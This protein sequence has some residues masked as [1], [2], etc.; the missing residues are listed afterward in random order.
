M[1]TVLMDA[2]IGEVAMCQCK[3][4]PSADHNTCLDG[5][6][7]KQKEQFVV[8]PGTDG[9]LALSITRDGISQKISADDLFAG[10]LFGSSFKACSKAASG[11]S[12][13]T[14]AGGSAGFSGLYDGG[15]SIINSLLPFNASR[16]NATQ[17]RRILQSDTPNLLGIQ[18]PIICLKV[19]QGT[20][21]Q[22][23]PST[24]DLSK[25]HYPVYSRNSLFNSNTN[26]DY[27]AFIDLK[28]RISN[29]QLIKAFFYSFTDPGMYSFEDSIDSSKQMFIGVVAASMECPSAF[30]TNAIQPM[31][32]SIL[33]QFPDVRT[34]SASLT[35]MPDYGLIIGLT[36]G[37]VALLVL[38]SLTVFLLKKR[39]FGRHSRSGLYRQSKFN[40]L[41]DIESHVATEKR[42]EV[43]LV[44]SGV[45]SIDLEGFNVNTLWSVMQK[46]T[47]VLNTELSHQKEEVRDFYDKVLR[48]IG[49]IP[50][51]LSQ[52]GP[53]QEVS[54]TSTNARAIVKSPAFVAS[55][56][57]M[58]GLSS[59]IQ[60]DRSPHLSSSLSPAVSSS[61]PVEQLPVLP[62]PE[63]LLSQKLAE[64]K[65]L[66]DADDAVVLR[67]VQ[68]FI[69]DYKLKCLGELPAAHVS[70]REAFGAAIEKKRD[71]IMEVV[72]EQLELSRGR[73]L[74]D[75]NVVDA[76]IA[77][78]EAD[79]LL[80]KQQLQS[81]SRDPN[82]SAIEL[83]Q[84]RI[85]IEN[86]ESLINDLN[87]MAINHQ[88][89]RKDLSQKLREEFVIPM[90]N[91]SVQEDEKKALI[92]RMHEKGERMDKEL[93]AEQQRQL[94]MA[95]KSKSMAK[96]R[97]IERLAKQRAVIDA[98]L[99]DPINA[100]K[101]DLSS[102]PLSLESIDESVRQLDVDLSK[103]EAE[104]LGQLK[105]RLEVQKKEVLLQEAN[106]FERSIACI[107]DSSSDD[108]DALRRK[109]DEASSRISNYLD[110]EQAKQE[111][112]LSTAFAQLK[113]RKKIKIQQ[114]LLLQQQ[115]Q[116]LDAEQ[117]AQLV[118]EVVK[119]KQESEQQRIQV[120]SELVQEAA[121]IEAEKRSA[122]QDEKLTLT[123]LINDESD[124]AQKE[125]LLK[126]I[127]KLDQSLDSE[128]LRQSEDFKRR[129]EQAKAAKA[130][131]LQ[132]L[133]ERQQL[134]LQ[135]VIMEMDV[136]VEAL[137]CASSLH[138]DSDAEEALLLSHHKQLDDLNTDFL[139]RLEVERSAHQQEFERLRAEQLELKEQLLRQQEQERRD[140]EA[141]LLKESQ[142]FELEMKQKQE[143]KKKEMEKRLKQE[144]LESSAMSEDEKAK[145]LKHH[146][147]QIASLDREMAAEKA[148]QQEILKEKIAERRYRVRLQEEKIK[149]D[150][151]KAEQKLREELQSKLHAAEAEQLAKI[152]ASEVDK[153]K[154]IKAAQVMLHER[155]RRELLEMN[156][157]HMADVAQAT[158]S[159]LQH[160][161]ISHGQKLKDA[162]AIFERSIEGLSGQA[163]DK[164]KNDHQMMVQRMDDKF[165]LEQTEVEGR[166]LQQVADKHRQEVAMF[167]RRREAE[168]RQGAV[169]EIIDI[170]PINNATDDIAAQ[171]LEQTRIVNEDKKLAL[172]KLFAE[173]EKFMADQR[174]KAIAEEEAFLARLQEEK[175]KAIAELTAQQQ[176]ELEAQKKQLQDIQSV[177]E[178]ELIIKRHQAKAQNIEEDLKAER[179][180]QER[181]AAERF[182]KMKQRK[183][184]LRKAKV[185][186]DVNKSSEIAQAQVL[187][188]RIVRQ[189]TLNASSESRQREAL[190]KVIEIW[191]SVC[192]QVRQEHVKLKAVTRFKEMLSQ[193]IKRLGSIESRRTHPVPVATNVHNVSVAPGP[194]LSISDP[195][196][197]EQFMD[198]LQ[199]S[200][201]SRELDDIKRL[202]QQ[203]TSSKTAAAHHDAPVV[204]KPGASSAPKKK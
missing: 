103:Q 88:S 64:S 55:N 86:D 89:I 39:G 67:H 8:G 111:K 75:N 87:E 177:E 45:S 2:S 123:K 84:L 146:Q 175:I 29:G 119:H 3:C 70:Q 139:E 38:S 127:S 26:F 28:D 18:S 71:E 125:L 110:M 10:G 176:R 138:D 40:A 22:V 77:R 19:G 144:D 105:Q 44:S 145:V 118:A 51:I 23:I 27:G 133:E 161:E 129:M 150:A 191:Q 74:R 179:S 60:G 80:K 58:V 108:R 52:V 203:L 41:G 97:R 198:L 148:R 124:E 185:I 165:K 173:K 90:L 181:A 201:L 36:A 17:G 200:S 106:R 184:E 109:Y 72:K 135:N 7:V 113:E 199:R 81:K 16:S 5:S 9:S 170:D 31:S 1:D 68:D 149:A 107:P 151:E 137:V 115:Q 116:Q 63:E 164:A 6:S 158:S 57:E 156:A 204:H 48:E 98:A 96:Q 11:C 202:L 102:S 65:I 35:L 95:E 142:Q 174:V 93:Y 197:Q 13:Q 47:T 50:V 136:K 186:Q 100:S 37:L 59:N 122:I 166:V 147:Q 130:K 132:E 43:S 66:L 163:L 53:I 25:I 157:R 128:K 121:R 15:G 159:A 154:V 141:E 160:L 192:P 190:K 14:V 30:A 92:A 94:D 188:K 33:K 78:L 178:R 73:F 61:S 32:S 83:A 62:T 182:E 187:E 193:R 76:A 69:T 168:L 183:A 54:N 155:H 194:A 189:E 195:A 134:E 4:P 49:R 42:R 112:E 152:A 131:R 180:K 56:R 153:E 196:F 140:L 46:Q 104:A 79:L 34:E 101:L 172:E 12:F 21:F 117:Q 91:P 167:E 171:V 126:K 82:V 99:V 24:T 143:L 20:L 85:L 169:G 114:K 120:E 162:E